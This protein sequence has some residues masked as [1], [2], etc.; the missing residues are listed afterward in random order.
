MHFQVKNILKNNCYHTLKHPL[1]LPKTN[2]KKSKKISIELECVVTY[3]TTL[4]ELGDHTRLVTILCFFFFF[5]FFS[6]NI[7][8]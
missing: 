8:F 3:S 4:K 2:C 7:F 6:I 5:D 1:K